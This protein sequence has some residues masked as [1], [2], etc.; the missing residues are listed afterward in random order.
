MAASSTMLELGTNL[1]SFSLPDTTSGVVISSDSL[2]GSIGVVAF[3]CNHC[4]YVKHIQ[5]GF[6]GFAR[7]YG[8]RGVKVLAISPNDVQSHPEDGPEK[9]AEEA[10]AAGYTF[11]YLYDESQ[12]VALAFRA[13]CTPE[14]YV[15]DRASKLAYRGRFDESTVRNG[16]PVTGKDARAAVDALIAGERPGP[17]QKPSIG[18]SIKWKPGV[19]PSF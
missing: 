16:L 12:S 9:M 13:A 4:P 17:D 5:R 18:C 15:F 10:R 1:P 3:L 19:T 6:S 2:S 7:E 14:I 11:P 8:G